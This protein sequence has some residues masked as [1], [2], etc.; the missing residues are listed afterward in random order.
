MGIEVNVLRVFTDEDGKHGNPLGIID[1]SLVA[2]PDR[3]TV[4]K[5]LGYSETL[6]YDVIDDADTP[7]RV[8][9][10]TPATELPF[11]GH[12]TVG[13]AWW[14]GQ[15]GLSV[16]RLDTPAGTVEVRRSGELTWVRARPEWAPEFAI[17]PMDSVSEVLHADASDFDADHS[18]LW[19]WQDKLE[20]SIRTR[21][22][23][24][25]MGIP[26]DEATGS[27]ALRITERLR[28]SLLITQGRGSVLHTT[29][30]PEGWLEVGGRVAVDPSRT[31]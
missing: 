30:S 31:L 15:Q 21:M 2:E 23:A 6:F 7:T 13:I 27:A 26:E 29:F 20:S 10:F 11:A 9:I 8:Q 4:A 19:A 28:K 17:Y 16:T 3:Q 25:T 5:E 18:Y 14:L 24:P 12:P 1:A 22:F